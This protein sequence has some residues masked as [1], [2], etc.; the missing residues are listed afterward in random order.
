MTPGDIPSDFGFS[1]NAASLS[2]VND[3][4]KK[5]KSTLDDKYDQFGQWYVYYF[6]GRQLEDV[7]R[8]HKKL[9]R[10]LNIQACMALLSVVEA[11]LKTDFVCR[12]RRQKR[13]DPDDSH[14]VDVLASYD[15]L[16]K[17]RIKEDLIDYWKEKLKTEV[18]VHHFN[19]MKE[20]IDYRNWIAHG[21]YWNKFGNAGREKF[22][23]DSLYIEV[24]NFMG[25]V[26]PHLL[27]PND[28]GEKLR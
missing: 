22:S 11:T 4:Y 2:E 8:E 1:K 15:K 7:K 25:E 24:N 20:R 12:V 21:R 28:I 10:E 9:M 23:F 13:K 14:F 18:D 3:Y 17:V 6:I 19:I 26:C 5:V 27:R 16:Y